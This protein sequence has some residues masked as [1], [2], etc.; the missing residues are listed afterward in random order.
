L[1]AINLAGVRMDST[2]ANTVIAAMRQS[3]AAGKGVMG[4]KILGE[5]RLRDRLDPALRFALGIDCLDCF[6]I[7]AANRGELRDLI[8]RVPA[9]SVAAR[10]A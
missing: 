2:N 9:N 5:G 7:G 6:A 1:Q 8:Q 10:A 4:M 3:K